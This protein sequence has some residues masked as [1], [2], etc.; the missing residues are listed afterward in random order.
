MALF[1]PIWPYSYDPIIYHRHWVDV[2][3][4]SQLSSMPWLDASPKEG[5]DEVV[6]SSSSSSTT[7]TTSSTT[8]TTTSS[9]SSDSEKGRH[10]EVFKCKAA[11]KQD[12]IETLRAV[13][14]SD[15]NLMIKVWIRVF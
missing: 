3:S 4:K 10:G 13:T 14:L 15:L 6:S 5:N 8:T 11:C 1:D 12:W 7:T 9:S 2:M